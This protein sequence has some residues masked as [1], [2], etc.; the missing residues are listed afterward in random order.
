MPKGKPRKTNPQIY[1][2]ITARR[3]NVD[4]GSATYKR[5]CTHR[6]KDEDRTGTI[7]DEW[8]YNQLRAECVERGIY[9]KDM[10]KVVMI[11][12]LAG[13]D[14]E[15]KRIEREA[16]LEHENRRLQLAREK[17]K[18]AI[19]R[20]K[21]EAEKQKQLL[22]KQAK[23]DQDESVSEDTPDEEDLQK[24]HNELLDHDENN[25]AQDQVGRALSEESWD[26]TST[27]STVYSTSPIVPGCRIR[28]FEWSYME[29]PS[30]I[31]H[32][33]Q[34]SP[35]RPNE[36]CVFPERAP[37]STQ[38]VPLKV[39][40]TES[41][42][43]LFLPGQMYPPGVDPDYVPVLSQETRRAARNGILQGV[44]SKATI[45]PASTWTSRTRIQGWNARM[46]FNLPPHNPSKKLSEV[47][48]KWNL[49][50]RKLLRVKPGGGG[51][52]IEWQKR[53]EQ[54]H[55]QRHKNRGKRYAEV[56]EASEHRPTAMCYLPAFLD[57][58]TDRPMTGYVQ[59]KPKRSKENLFFIRFLGCDVPHY[60]FWTQ[61]GE[62]VNPAIPNPGWKPEMKKQHCTDSGGKEKNGQ[63][64]ENKPL[65]TK[66]VHLRLRKVYIRRKKAIVP[67]LSDTATTVSLIEHELYTAGLAAT[68]AKYRTK[69]IAN[70]KAHAWE[71]FGRTLPLLYPGGELP[72]VPPS[73]TE[74][75]VSIAEKMA[76][77]ETTDDKT[78]HPPLTGS[79]A[80]TTNDNAW[81][82]TVVTVKCS[83]KPP[84]SDQATRKSKTGKTTSRT[85]GLAEPE[86]LF[87]R[88]SE[89]F[90]GFEKCSPWLGQI[91]PPYTPLTIDTLPELSEPDEV[92][93]RIREEW[94]NKVLQPSQQGMNIDCPFC[95]LDLGILSFEEQA[96]HMHSHSVVKDTQFQ[97]NFV[98]ECSPL[99]IPRTSQ[100]SSYHITSCIDNDF[101]TDDDADN[102]YDGPAT[103]QRLSPS[104]Q[105]RKKA[106]RQVSQEAF[107]SSTTPSSHIPSPYLATFKKYP[108]NNP[109]AAWNPR[110]RSCSS[111][112]SLEFLEERVCQ[113]L[114]TD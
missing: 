19:R 1:Q 59:R 10:K 107:E 92:E 89:Q 69:W 4:P 21:A 18:E 100:G 43:K 112:E 17:K 51:S 60:Y 108:T 3:R 73:K 22:E 113:K 101:H 77:I 66:Q 76:N 50:N 79:E 37:R 82:E 16:A 68:L 58:D 47:Y 70:N 12:T 33:S 99:D 106:T 52:K 74:G 110:K 97:R 26:S 72:I 78:I 53:H 39:L 75:T 34:Y 65:P 14:R 64:T 2:G 109:N 104:T 91:S 81:W 102:E 27:E 20:R 45:E 32:P 48:A 46:F 7:F 62:W 103:R 56:L 114:R 87:R 8:D 57:F 31:A 93:I 96:E 36:I 105:K 29:M 23:R 67:T 90:L 11:K 80:W 63:S 98:T 84:L 88:G 35:T 41:K 30:W 95:L 55:A 25:A 38:Y 83:Y 44:L 61:R 15:K 71:V 49:E 42:E 54:R 40:T 111:V 13:N 94:E 9:M 24:I 6:V 28:L 5:G 85:S 86:A